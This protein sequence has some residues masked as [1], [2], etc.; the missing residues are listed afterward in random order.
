MDV[1][2]PKTKRWRP[3]SLVGPEAAPRKKVLSHHITSP[4]TPN[5]TCGVDMAIES[6]D[7]IGEDE[8][9]AGTVPEMK[10][11]KAV[12]QRRQGNVEALHMFVTRNNKATQSEAVR[13]SE[14]EVQTIVQPQH[15][16]GTQVLNTTPRDFCFNYVVCVFVRHVKLAPLCRLLIAQRN[17]FS[18][19]SSRKWAVYV[20]ISW[21]IPQLLD[22]P[23]GQVSNRRLQRASLQ[24]SSKSISMVSIA[25]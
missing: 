17:L 9:G 3:R 2:L 14:M 15:C 1:W 8:A 23:H 20:D 16:A 10:D 11:W 21:I 4:R 7:A 19:I 24:I 13:T 5:S 18:H 25:S 6:G 12:M 22:D